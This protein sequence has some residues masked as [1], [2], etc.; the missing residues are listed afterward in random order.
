ME[1]QY[2]VEGHHTP[3][4]EKSDWLKVQQL[5]KENRHRKRQIRRRKPRIMVKGVLAGF[6]LVDFE[7]TAEDIETVFGPVPST[8]VVNPAP[9][10]DDAEHF[11]IEKE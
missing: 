11:V 3:I 6:M 1:P 7:W 5:L 10:L 8:T 4:I 9:L 2:F